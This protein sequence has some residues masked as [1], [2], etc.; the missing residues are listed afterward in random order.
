MFWDSDPVSTGQTVQESLLQE[1]ALPSSNRPSDHVWN[2]G[3]FGFDVNH[4]P[5][6]FLKRGLGVACGYIHVQ[7]GG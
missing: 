4:L 2:Q 1:H 7:G 5:R 3:T 6:L